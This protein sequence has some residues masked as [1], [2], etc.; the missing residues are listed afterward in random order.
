M[1]RPLC[2]HI[3]YLIHCI[4]LAIIY[5][6]SKRSSDKKIPISVKKVKRGAVE[7]RKISGRG[8]S[9]NSDSDDQGNFDFEPDEET[10]HTSTAKNTSL[11]ER[12]SGSGDTS[13]D[14]EENDDEM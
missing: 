10:Q 6:R 12:I 14:E 2:H 13:H 4:Y 8:N 11:V 5:L 9:S 3:F 1:L 7:A